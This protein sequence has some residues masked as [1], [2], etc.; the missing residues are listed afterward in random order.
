MK[1]V[2]I[3]F[4]EESGSSVD[5]SVMKLLRILLYS[6]DQLRVQSATANDSCWISPHD[7]ESGALPSVTDLHGH[8]YI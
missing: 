8:L 4:R 5:Q 6:Y 7:C 1:L 2:Q 3:A